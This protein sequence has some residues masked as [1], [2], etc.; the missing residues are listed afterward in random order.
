MFGRSNVKE[1]EV[2]VGDA[3]MPGTI[4]FPAKPGIS[5]E[6]EWVDAK[7]ETKIYSLH[8]CPVGSVHHCS[9]HTRQG[10]SKGTTLK[11]L[12]RLNGHGFV[13]Y[14]FGW[15][16]EGTVI[17]WRGG[18]MNKLTEGC[19]GIQLL[20]AGGARVP[21]EAEGAHGISS[22][23]AAIQALNP[24]VNLMSLRFQCSR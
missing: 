15:D 3:I 12:E 19:L 16:F 24:V 11:T 14:G 10:V 17:S 13:L 9:W 5:F 21:R 1:G 22:S 23:N 4:V 7:A 18:R 6:V 20:P 8:F 2:G